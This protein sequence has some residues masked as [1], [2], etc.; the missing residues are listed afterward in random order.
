MN[1]ATLVLEK[2][3]AQR[4]APL[5]GQQIADELKV[6]RNAVWKAVAT[7]R[8]SGCIIDA[9]PRTGYRL[10][11]VPEPLDEERVLPGVDR[12]LYR[13][14]HYVPATD[15]TN[16]LAKQHAKAGA[17]E[18]TVVITDRQLHGRGRRGRAWE[19]TAGQSLLFSIV[20]RPDIPPR[21][22]PLLVFLAAAAVRASL[23]AHGNVFIKWPND[24]V[25][26]DGRKLCGI[27][28]E[29]DAEHDRVR[30]CIVGIG[31]NVSQRQQ[32]FAAQL[33]GSATSVQLLAGGPVSRLQLLQTILNEFAQR[34]AVALRT[35]FAE[36][37][38]D[39]RRFSATLGRRVRVHEQSGD[40]WNGTAVDLRSDGA[41]LVRPAAGADALAVYAA[42]VSIRMED[43]VNEP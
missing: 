40:T 31:I 27:L 38:H 4:G 14:I 2:L 17:P 19:T 43:V 24:I 16:D 9:E 34:Y 11:S 29:M 5:S 22:A 10:V 37:L 7:L 41:L 33:Q 25:A 23:S 42:D 30:H 12:N 8:D 13:A 21:Q 39:A 20:L 35:D 32:D 3:T 28:V 6:S 1:T 15:S 36:V 26:E 18:G